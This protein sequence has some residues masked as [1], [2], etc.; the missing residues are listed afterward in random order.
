MLC[1]ILVIP[2]VAFTTATLAAP[3]PGEGDGFL[4][5]VRQ[6][7]GPGREAFGR[8]EGTPRPAPRTGWSL[9]VTCGVV[10]T[11]TG[12]ETVLYRGRGDATVTSRGRSLGAYRPVPDVASVRTSGVEWSPNPGQGTADVVA[13]G[14]APCPSGTA[15]LSSGD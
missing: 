2:L 5:S 15:D 12:R 11:R 4:M 7:A 14:P 8:W 13:H 3:F 6:P 9:T 1:R 10:D